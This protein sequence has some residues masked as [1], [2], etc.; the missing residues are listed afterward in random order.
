M[1]DSWWRKED[2]QFHVIRGYAEQAWGQLE[3]SLSFLAGQPTHK[4]FKISIVPADSEG[5]ADVKPGLKSWKTV[6]LEPLTMEDII[7]G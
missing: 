3:A 2:A 4:S 1:S 6:N 5:D 7:S